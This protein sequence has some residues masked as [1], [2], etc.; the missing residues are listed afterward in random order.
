MVVS[1]S[2]GFVQRKKVSSVTTK[3]RC[4][5]HVVVMYTYSGIGCNLSCNMMIHLLYETQ[6]VLSS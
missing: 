4:P 1:G 5:M 2:H 3:L 6:K